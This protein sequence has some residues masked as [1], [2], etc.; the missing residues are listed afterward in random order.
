MLH[1]STKTKQKKK[2]SQLININHQTPSIDTDFDTNISSPTNENPVVYRNECLCETHYAKLLIEH[3]YQLTADKLFDLIFG[4]NEFVQTY[5][6]AQRFY[7]FI[8]FVKNIFEFYFLFSD[9]TA[10][11]WMKNE[12]TNCRERTLKYKVP[13]ESTF[14]GKGTI[15]TREKQVRIRMYLIFSNVSFLLI[16]DTF[17]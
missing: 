5:R 2:N 9:D 16:L 4:S 13:Y 1:R 17:A 15:L 7:G 11:E 6:Q 10:T 3:T 14:V 12:A 8:I